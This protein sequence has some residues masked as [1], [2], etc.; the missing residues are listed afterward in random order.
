MRISAA[1]AADWTSNT[2]VNDLRHTEPFL[3][4]TKRGACV[5]LKAVWL[6]GGGGDDM[7][8]VPAVR[9]PPLPP[10]PGNRPLIMGTH[11]DNNHQQTNKRRRWHVRILCDAEP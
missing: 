4:T 5:C 8:V 6:A 2:E 7:C 9:C 1:N 3:L 11:P 10:C